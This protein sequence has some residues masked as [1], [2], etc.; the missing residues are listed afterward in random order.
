MKIL[1]SMN[2]ERRKIRSCKNLS[3]LFVIISVT[4]LM[5]AYILCKPL[6]TIKAEDQNILATLSSDLA[7]KLR[8]DPFYE[9]M[10]GYD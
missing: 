10:R 6:E 8:A 2:E 5:I 1:E 7:D 9:A 3:S 4:L